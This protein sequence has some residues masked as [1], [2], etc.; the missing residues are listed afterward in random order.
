MTELSNSILSTYQ[1]RKT[2]KQKDAFI[3]LLQTYFP[4]LSIQQGGIAKSRNLILG[5]V[6]GA[7]II[8]SAHYDTCAVLPFPNFIAPKKP[9]L[10]ILYS[11]LIAL[12]IIALIFLI[13][14]LL[15]WVTREFWVNYIACIGFCLL[16][17]YLMLA[18]PANKHT[19]NDN[20]SG[21][22]ALCELY[23][24]LSAEDREKIAVVFFDHEELGLFG[25]SMFRKN[26]KKEIQNKLLINLDCVS[27]GD[28]FLLAVNKAARSK[29]YMPLK[30][31]FSDSGEKH[32]LLEKAEKVYYPSDQSGFPMSVAVA[33]LKH[34]KFLGHYM[35]RI[36][37]KRD[38]VFDEKNIIFLTN[39]LQ[40][41]IQKL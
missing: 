17:V 3:A 38:I 19:A 5:D 36:H 16:T 39:A 14:Y 30:N 12:P 31:V 15:N 32:I 4:A 6:K 41:L 34:K 18:G 1:V 28:Y 26:Y 21:V 20:T 10:S 25:S 2:K 27:E 33:A 35:D 8:L 11:V 22:I 9:L 37:T 7:K 24:E 23:S 29:Y 40:K 13:S